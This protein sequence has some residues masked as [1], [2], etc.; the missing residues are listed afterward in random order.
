MATETGLLEADVH[1]KHSK[2]AY[3]LR[4]KTDKI[5]RGK[6]I[7]SKRTREQQQI[8]SLDKY[9]VDIGL[10]LQSFSFLPR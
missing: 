2:A 5:K 6:A 10:I 7:L 1:S 9:Q 3:L 4:Q 8:F